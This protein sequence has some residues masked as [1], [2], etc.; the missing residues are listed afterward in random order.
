MSMMNYRT[1]GYLL[2]AATD[3]TVRKNI[4]FESLNSSFN[5]EGY[6][7][8][9]E[10]PEDAAVN[11]INLQFSRDNF[12]WRVILEGSQDMQEWFTV[13]ED[14]RIMAMK[15]ELTSF[16][17]TTLSFPESK[18]RYYR[19][20]INSSED[21]KLLGATIIQQETIPGKS[22]PV[23]LQEWRV[24]ENKKTGDT[25][26]HIIFPEKRRIY[27][28]SLDISSFYDYY[29]PITIKQIDSVRVKTAPDTYQTV[30]RAQT[31]NNQVLNSMEKAVFTFPGT[32][33]SQLFLVIE[34]GN[35]QPLSFENVEVRANE[36]S[37]IARF[38]EPAS[39]YLAYGNERA[40]APIY[41]IVNFRNK[42]PDTPAAISIG[43]EMEQKQLVQEK[44]TPLFEN[45]WWLWAVMIGLIL[46]LGIFSINMIRK[47]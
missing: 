42:I 29:R 28:V 22:N 40:S 19:I 17:F 41:D 12:D 35:N 34:N 38:T 36:Y 15:N 43:E 18:Y 11:K 13:L 26:I 44:S 8:T 32:T 5:S 23:A 33:T 27:Q 14:Y 20:R 9:F 46:L 37:L 45:S 39:Y 1:Y 2:D 31:L 24:T 10:V 3:K 25:E 21:P 4:A 30:A 6:Y 47:A 16:S 7:R